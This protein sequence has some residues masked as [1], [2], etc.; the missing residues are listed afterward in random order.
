MFL[1]ITN[2]SFSAFSS[3]IFYFILV[4]VNVLVFTFGRP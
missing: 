1:I 2:I 4:L 3:S